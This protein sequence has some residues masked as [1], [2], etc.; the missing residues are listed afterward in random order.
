[1]DLEKFRVSNGFEKH[2]FV[3]RLQPHIK[4]FTVTEQILSGL[5]D[6]T[7]HNPD[8]M[9]SIEIAVRKAFPEVAISKEKLNRWRLKISK[10]WT[11]LLLV[12]FITAFSLVSVIF[13]KDH[14]FFVGFEKF[15]GVF[16]AIAGVVGFIV[17][18]GIWSKKS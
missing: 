6:G 16:G 15:L 11:L 17:G 12:I 10:K 2:E 18:L 14:R 4:G 3:R 8:R 9:R 1:M 7:I 13:F 5:E